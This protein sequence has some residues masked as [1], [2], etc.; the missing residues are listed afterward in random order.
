MSDF[1]KAVFL[2]FRSSFFKFIRKLSP[3]LKLTIFSG[4]YPMNLELSGF[5]RNSVKP[6]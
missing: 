6:I 5:N 2:K 3:D 1:P 4:V